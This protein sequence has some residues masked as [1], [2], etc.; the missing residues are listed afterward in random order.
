MPYVRK[1]VPRLELRK[2]VLSHYGAQCVCC[3]EYNNEFLTIDHIYG[4]GQNHRK[5]IGG[6]DKL[7][8][9]IIRNDFPS[10]LQIL[11]MN[12]NFAKGVYGACPHQQKGF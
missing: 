6:S 9:W 11:C 2:Q 7:Y 3:G 1:D 4:N 12:C 8:R 10:D 5:E